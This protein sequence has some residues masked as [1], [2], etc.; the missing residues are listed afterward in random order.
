[1][2]EPA[3][4]QLK[5]Q[6]LL[7]ALVALDA[8][9]HHGGIFPFSPTFLRDAFSAL[10]SKNGAMVQR[11]LRRF[12]CSRRTQARTE[13]HAIGAKNTKKPSMDSR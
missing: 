10:G 5:A 12:H 1:M 7:Q 2:A 11:R 3:A 9:D 6:A 13:C 8:V 4:C